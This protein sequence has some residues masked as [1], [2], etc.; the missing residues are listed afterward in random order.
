MKVIFENVIGEVFVG[1]LLVVVFLG[2]IV[3]FVVDEESRSKLYIKLTINKEKIGIK[4][5]SHILFM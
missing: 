3:I 5:I 2:I 4:I 1:T